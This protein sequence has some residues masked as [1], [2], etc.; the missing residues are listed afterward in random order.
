MLKSVGIL[1]FTRT[2]L[3]SCGS[4]TCICYTKVSNKHDSEQVAMIWHSM[5]TY[6]IKSAS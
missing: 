3:N 2:I 1:I 4:N 6:D 5:P